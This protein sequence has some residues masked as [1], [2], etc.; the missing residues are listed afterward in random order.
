MT[1]DTTPSGNSKFPPFDSDTE[2]GA[3]I[4]LRK[5]FQ[6]NGVS[7]GMRHV[8]SHHWYAYWNIMRIFRSGQDWGEQ[9]VWS[10]LVEFFVVSCHVF[11]VR[12][13]FV[14]ICR[15]GL[16]FQIDRGKVKHN[17]MKPVFRLLLVTTPPFYKKFTN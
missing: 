16:E 11:K 6:L 9:L 17:P 12:E 4:T 2:G 13:P 10:K 1:E 5:L 14:I 7:T 8:I 15:T 3:R